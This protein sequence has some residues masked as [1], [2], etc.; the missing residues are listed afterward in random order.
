MC[1]NSRE[2]VDEVRSVER[3]FDRLAFSSAPAAAAT[4]S[5]LYPF[6]LDGVAAEPEL[7]QADGIHPTKEGVSEI[8]KR[9][10]PIGRKLIS[11]I[12]KAG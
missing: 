1:G 2:L 12:C 11:Q 8:V 4:T 9:F 5:L 3:S 7:N 10:M 6:F